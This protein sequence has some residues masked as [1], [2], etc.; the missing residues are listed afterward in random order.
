MAINVYLTLF[1][2]YNAQQL[3]AME[4]RYHIGCYGI[5]FVIALTLVF[6]ETSSKHRVYGDAAVSSQVITRRSRY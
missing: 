4:W 1:K 6:V 2:K 3:K 5:P